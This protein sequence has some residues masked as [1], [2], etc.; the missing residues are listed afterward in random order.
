MSLATTDNIDDATAQ[1]AASEGAVVVVPVYNAPD[2]VLRCF[3]ALYTHTPSSA[4]I[5]LVDDV[6]V[7]RRAIEAVARAAER[8]DHTVVIYHRPENGGFVAG[9]NDA[10]D[11]AVGRDVILVN[12]DVVVGPEWYDRM[13]AAARSS[14]TIATVS[15]LTNFGTILSVPHRNKPRAGLPP[16]AT[17]ESAAKAIAEAAL[18][19]LPTIPTGV[20]HCL[21]IRRAAL[22]AIGGFD[23]AFDKGYGEEVDF[24]QRAIAH[25]FHHVC[26]DDVFVYHRG[27][28]SF[29]EEG[30]AVQR[31]NERLVNSRYP[32]YPHAVERA[33]NDE[34]SPLAHAIEVAKRALLGYRVGIDARALGMNWAGT[35]VVAY[36]TIVELCRRLTGDRVVVYVTTGLAASN[37]RMLEDLG[38]VIEFVDDPATHEGPV[39]DV[40]YRPYQVGAMDELRFLL[41]HGE[42]VVVSQL[43]IIAFTNPAY[44]GNDHQWI[45]YRELTRAVLG[46]V[47]GVTFIS[48]HVL[49][50]V[51]KEDLLP[52]STPAS[53]T[54]C[55]TDSFLPVRDP[56]PVTQLNVDSRPILL[57]LGNAYNHKN[58]PFVLGLLSALAERGL[59]CQAVLAGAVPP[60]GS[61]LGAEAARYLDD[62]ALR[63]SVTELGEISEDQKQ[64]LFS[65]AALVVY[66]TV[67]EGFGLVPFEAARHGVPTLCTRQGSL[68]EVLPADLPTIDDFDLATAA[69][70]AHSM[71]TDPAVRESTVATLGAR[72]HEYTWARTVDELLAHFDTVLKRPRNRTRSV[73]GE[74]QTPMVIGGATA[75]R[76]RARRRQL[77]AQVLRLQRLTGPRRLLAPQGSKR[78]AALRSAVN[79]ARVRAQIADG[80]GQGV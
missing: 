62:P 80:R 76:A 49:D 12:S 57:C 9:C 56:T 7:E 23:P 10:F 74:L 66:P 44:F 79:W 55:G 33:L 26:A 51:R 6:G 19:L 75:G 25:G 69:G 77:D 73:V 16:G 39:V 46:S 14:N 40:L 18:G 47:D 63:A 52:T 53:V 68:D 50:A 64:W 5:L 8:T 43:D 24:S 27:N 17:A 54:Y 67:S 48:Q 30:S 13:S 34:H 45:D 35:Q 72:S 32:S 11:I 42:R 3:D 58:R 78:Q 36:N 37:V 28:A 65:K 31:S 4:A 59:P 61:S 71:I 38:A 21:Y 29:G 20:G 2:D 70:L 1:L 41:R 60:Y 15:T 22:N